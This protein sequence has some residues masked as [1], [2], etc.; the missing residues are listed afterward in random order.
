M[1]SY[2]VRRWNTRTA[3]GQ[4]LIVLLAAGPWPS[5]SPPAA[6][7]QPPAGAGQP[8]RV[9]PGSSAGAAL[10]PGM[11]VDGTMRTGRDYYTGTLVGIDGTRVRLQTIPLPGAKPSEF[12][13]S[14]IAAFHTDAG[15]FAYDP[16]ASR[17]VPALTYY[18]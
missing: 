2:P 4:A 6:L 17:F 8:S 10:E 9:P 1:T 18:R 7:G 16:W 15:T 11:R 14:N 13:L 3:V 12:D 5:G